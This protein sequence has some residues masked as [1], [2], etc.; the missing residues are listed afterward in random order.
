MS[1]N[2][3]EFR[4]GIETP[5][6]SSTSGT[7]PSASSPAI[8]YFGLTF[9][10]ESLAAR[11]L[12][13]GVE[14]QV[15]EYIEVIGND[16]REDTIDGKEVLVTDSDHSCLLSLFFEK[17]RREGRGPLLI[18]R[19]S[20]IAAP[21]KPE[22]PANPQGQAG[23]ADCGHSRAPPLTQQVHRLLHSRGTASYSARHSLAPPLPSI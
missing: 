22:L 13:L 6:A 5:I 23:A 18:V 15:E 4:K 10:A 3:S 21:T 9:Y 14:L 11:A 12:G 17:E 2:P 7:A 1:K 8:L 20:A 19:V 16:G